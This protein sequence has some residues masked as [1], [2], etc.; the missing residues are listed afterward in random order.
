METKVVVREVLRGRI[1][2]AKSIKSQHEINTQAYKVSNIS[3][4]AYEYM[5]SMASRPIGPH[6]PARLKK[7]QAYWPKMTKKQRLEFHIAETLGTNSFEYE[8]LK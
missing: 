5:T 8:V 2:R 3:K 1:D 4:E 7:V 6:L